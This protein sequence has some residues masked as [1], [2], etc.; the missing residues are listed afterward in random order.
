MAKAHTAELPGTR[1]KV[2]AHFKMKYKKHQLITANSWLQDVYC[3]VGMALQLLLR[4][5]RKVMDES[6]GSLLQWTHWGRTRCGLR[7]AL[8][9]RQ[10]WRA[11][12]ELLLTT[13][14]L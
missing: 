3:F 5:G 1:F 12:E 13:P 4:E 6:N 10:L 8:A 11:A 2:K 14:S 9:A 7:R